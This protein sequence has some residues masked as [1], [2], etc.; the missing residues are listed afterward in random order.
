MKGIPGFGSGG[1]NRLRL[2][3]E[4]TIDL[5]KDKGQE[6]ASEVESVCNKEEGIVYP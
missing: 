4:S 5:H 3:I 2:I 1:K 6:V